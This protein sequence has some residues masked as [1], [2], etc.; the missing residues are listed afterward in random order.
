MSTDTLQQLLADGQ[1]HAVSE[2]R[3]CAS[4]R[5]GLYRALERLQAQALV[6]RVARGIYRLEA[7]PGDGQA[8]DYWAQIGAQVPKGVVCLLSALAFHGIGTQQPGA[9]WLAIPRGAWRPRTDWPPLRLVHFAD[10]AHA[11]GVEEHPRDGGQVRVYSPAKTVADCFKFRHRIGLD[12]A[13][14]AL[15]EGWQAQRFTLPELTAMARICRVERVLRPY[16]E[17]LTA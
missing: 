11:A 5:A 16:V 8:E 14:E 3:G 15:R 2:L 12:V 10:A 7:H 4:S 1:D 9:V 6:R 17:A 13:L